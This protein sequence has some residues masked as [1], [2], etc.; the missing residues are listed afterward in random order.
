ML[1]N[2]DYGGALEGLQE[3]PV[4]S[5]AFHMRCNKQKEQD[6]LHRMEDEQLKKSC[7]R[8]MSAGM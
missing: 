3:M 4:S 1:D 5:V 8:C 6:W 2:G 7:L